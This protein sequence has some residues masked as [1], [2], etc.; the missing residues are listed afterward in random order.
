MSFLIDVDLAQ[1]ASNSELDQDE[2]G[3]ENENSSTSPD[4]DT[5]GLREIGFVMVRIRNQKLRQDLTAV[6]EPNICISIACQSRSNPRASDRF[7]S[8]LG[9]QP[10]QQAQDHRDTGRTTTVLI[11][12]RILAVDNQNSLAN[13]VSNSVRFPNRPIA[14][15]PT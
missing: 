5:E 8:S 14:K 15:I 9:I 6:V 13:L 3:S 12:D 1:R 7:P 10:N 4:T 2:K 11:C